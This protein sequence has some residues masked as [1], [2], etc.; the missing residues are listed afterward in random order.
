M[1][2]VPGSR[3]KA[4]QM[5][6]IWL[7]FAAVAWWMTTLQDA[8]RY[9]LWVTHMVGWGLLI[10]TSLGAFGVMADIVRPPSLRLDANGFSVDRA[11]F[12]KH[13]YSWPDIVEFYL[14]NGRG[15]KMVRWKYD[16]S[17][18]RAGYVKLDGMLPT[19]LTPS[20][21]TLLATMQ[22]YWTA[23]VNR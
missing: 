6:P 23:A 15:P 16:Q 3:I 4:A 2:Y 7:A 19:A 1:D 10:V 21:E 14:H 5:L 9:P 12:G 13:R 11:L 22:K 17:G 18:V 20:P 8:H